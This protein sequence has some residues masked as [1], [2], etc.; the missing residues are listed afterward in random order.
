MSSVIR[1]LLLLALGGI[2]FASQAQVGQALKANTQYKLGTTFFRLPLSDRDMRQGLRLFGSV[3]YF[4]N[5]VLSFEA[6]GGFQRRLGTF[7]FFRYGGETADR[8]IYEYRTEHF[9]AAGIL[10]IHLNRVLLE[11]MG[12]R[13]PEDQVRLYQTFGM[14]WLN[15]RV[16]IPQSYFTTGGILDYQ[17]HIGHSDFPMT[18]K[19][20][21]RVRLT[22]MLG[23][24]FKIPRTPF[25]LM[26][27]AGLG[28]T[29]N[30]RT[31][32]VIVPK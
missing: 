31:G 24:Q 13:I 2:P 4:I 15:T 14:G 30:V 28:M 27:E 32:I 17:P 11:Y 26:V 23:L 5:P 22:T 10:H 3:E 12:I 19:D 25:G 21:H 29:S 20:G 6:T 18:W 8:E 16:L 7:N 9:Y 1:I